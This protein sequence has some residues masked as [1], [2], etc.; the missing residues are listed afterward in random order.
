MPMRVVAGFDVR[1]VSAAFPAIHYRPLLSA[2]AQAHNSAVGRAA[3]AVNQGLA[4]FESLPAPRLTPG[5][6]CVPFPASSPNVCRTV[7]PRHVGPP[8]VPACGLFF[9]QKPNP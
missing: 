3:A 9:A 5:V 2:I 8:Q 1:T 4:R 6:I 7:L